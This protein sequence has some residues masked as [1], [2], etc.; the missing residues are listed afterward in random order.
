MKPFTI[1]LWFD[2]E[3]EEAA[4]YY[5][6]IFKNGKLG[7]VTHYTNEGFEQHHQ[8]AGK[9]M[10]AEFEVNGQRFLGLNGGP[11]FK[12][13]ES[14]SLVI[15]C[16][17]QAEI[18]MYWDKLTANGGNPIECGWLKDKYGLTWQVVPTALEKMMSDE[19]QVKSDRVMHAMLQM[20][21]LDLAKLQDAYRG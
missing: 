2:N 12:F 8:P 21:K 19:D 10:T 18:D 20:K 3:A 17:S 4:K 15:N 7:Q 9:V 13:N 1:C 5:T 16:D 14:I 11:D 6:S